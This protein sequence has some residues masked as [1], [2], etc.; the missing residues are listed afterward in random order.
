M[1]TDK[2]FIK[3]FRTKDEAAISRMYMQFRQAF[4]SYFGSHYR[5]SEL[6]IDDVY[7]DSFT[8]LW[9]NVNSGKIT[10]DNLKCSLTTYLIAVG[11]YTMMARQR[12]YKEIVNDEMITMYY[13]G[14]MDDADEVMAKEERYAFIRRTVMQMQEPCASILDKFYWEDKTGEEIATDMSYK[15]TDVVKAQKYKCMQKLKAYLKEHG[16]E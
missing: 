5:K 6:E 9:Q 7:Q 15:N 12:R 2:E 13:T 1:A 10:E 4:F 16:I 11:R 8:V 14:K 3:E